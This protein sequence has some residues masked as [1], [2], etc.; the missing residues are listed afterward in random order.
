MWTHTE[1]EKGASA[2]FKRNV[3]NNKWYENVS[4]CVLGMQI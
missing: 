3:N 4:E 1:W 2:R